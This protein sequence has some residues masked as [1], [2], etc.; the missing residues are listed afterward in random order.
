MILRLLGYWMAASK[1]A[2]YMC[3]VIYDSASVGLLNGGIE[4][5]YIHENCDI[6]FCVCWVIECRHRRKVHTCILWYMILRLLGYWMAASKEA[7][8]MCTVI[9]DSA[10]VGLLNGGIEGSYI[11]VYCD[12][13]F[14]VCWVIEW[15]HRRKVHTCVL[16][17]MILRLLGYW[18]AASKE[19]T[20]MYTVI[21]DSASVGLLN[22]GIEGSYIHVY[23]DIWFCV[24]WVIE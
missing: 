6:W 24:C 12:I 11:H 14:C 7:T 10:S 23:C 2:T 19:G 18:M 20:Y 21:Y 17:Y 13:W 15:R 4:G 5:S 9:Y 16:W 1:E 3:T 22:G 8:Y